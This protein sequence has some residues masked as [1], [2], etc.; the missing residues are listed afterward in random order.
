MCLCRWSFIQISSHTRSLCVIL[1]LWN[2]RFKYSS[3][4]HLILERETHGIAWESESLF[5]CDLIKFK[6]N[7][8]LAIQ[9]MGRSKLKGPSGSHDHHRGLHKHRIRGC[10]PLLLFLSLISHSKLASCHHFLFSWNPICLFVSILVASPVKGPQVPFTR[11]ISLSS[12]RI[13]PSHF[14]SLTSSLRFPLCGMRALTPMLLLSSHPNIRSPRRYS[15]TQ[16]LSVLP[17]PQTLVC[18]LASRWTIKPALTTACSGYRWGL[19]TS[20]GDGWSWVSRRGWSQTHHLLQSDG[21]T[22]TD[23]D[24]P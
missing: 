20:D 11:M 17:G 1:E 22:G 18:G 14:H 5:A 6:S 19:C 10:G 9:Y 2:T 13:L 16:S 3:K 21:L 15:V 23:Q 8:M 7:G 12:N 24:S 4:S